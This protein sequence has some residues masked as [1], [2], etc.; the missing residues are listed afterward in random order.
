MASNTLIG[1]WATGIWETLGSPSS[2]SALTISGYAVQPSTLG[3]LNA[4]IGTCYSGT[5]Y[6]G[7]GTVFD[8]APELTNSELALVE[9]M[10]RVGWYSRLAQAMMGTSPSEIPWASISE[11]DTKISRANPVNLG[12]EYR[13]LAKDTQVH[14]NYLVNA[15]IQQ[16]QGGSTPRSVDLY[17]PGYPDIIFPYTS[18]G[19]IY[20]RG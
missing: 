20:W 18:P 12:K 15:Y 11:G 4:M 19:G 1:L 2:L 8:A 16:V 17:N 14:L 10:F 9:G 13:E 3:R 6:L 7:T 5:G